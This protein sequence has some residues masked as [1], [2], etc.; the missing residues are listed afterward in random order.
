MTSSRRS[1]GG[2]RPRR[3][4]AGVVLAVLLAPPSLAEET[5]GCGKFKWPIEAD[6]ALLATAERVPSG[7]QLDVSGPKGVRVELVDADKAG[8][9]VQPEKPYPPGAPAGVL[10]FEV[11]AGVYQITTTDR[12]WFDVVQDGKL[13]EGAEFSGVLDCDGARK[14][15][16]FRLKDGPA[17]LQLSG[18]PARTTAV[19]ISRMP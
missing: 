14:S 19:A 1:P 11:R 7:T 3:S 9:E 6:K 16:R 2:G 12:L 18:S 15:V 8:F 5:G 17:L 10:R 4:I 13:A